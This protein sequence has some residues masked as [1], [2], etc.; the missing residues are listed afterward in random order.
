[1]AKSKAYMPEKPGDVV[2]PMSFGQGRGQLFGGKKI[3]DIAKSDE[4]L[5]WLDRLRGRA[6]VPWLRDALR[7]YLDDPAIAAELDRLLEVE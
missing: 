2:L 3:D 7:D 1:M 5:L 6:R 4:G